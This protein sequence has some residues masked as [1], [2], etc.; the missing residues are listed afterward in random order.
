MRSPDRQPRAEPRAQVRQLRER[1][2]QS[3]VPPAA[4]LTPAEQAA[5]AHFSQRES[6]RYRTSVVQGA[7]HVVSVALGLPDRVDEAY[8]RFPHD[9]STVEGCIHT[10]EAQAAKYNDLHVRSESIEV[11]LAFAIGS[12][13]RL[14]ADQQQRLWDVM[15]P[16]LNRFW[17]VSNTLSANHDI[18]YTYLALRL[19]CPDH[20]LPQYA[21][22]PLVRAVATAPTDER[23]FYQALAA[24]LNNP[25][26]DLLAAVTQQGF[27]MSD[28]E[29]S[30]ATQR[31]KLQAF[32]EH[33]A[34]QV[35]DAAYELAKHLALQTVLV[36]P[37][38]VVDERG[39]PRCIF[40]SQVEGVVP[41]PHRPVV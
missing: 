13:Q 38:V 2:E 14:T 5:I 12:G 4:E 7:S 17:V 3:P 27:R 20:E 9:W 30:I 26:R 6:S 28:L 11:W 40:P 29:A 35:H 24:R 23:A 1:V 19:L 16:Q 31:T 25:D 18:E 15:W 10:V 21:D 39:R 32:G 8:A 36:A 34:W 22:K 41:L 37:Q 33:S